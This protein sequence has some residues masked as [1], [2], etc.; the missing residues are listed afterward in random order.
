MAFIQVGSGQLDLQGLINTVI[1]F[2]VAA[3]VIWLFFKLSD[4]HEKF[5]KAMQ[6][7]WQDFIKDIQED[8][9]IRDLGYQSA[10]R[11]FGNVLKDHTKV[12]M[13]VEVRKHIE[14]RDKGD[15]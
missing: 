5:V 4:K 9:K 11:E 10:L 3:I 1:Q 8:N 7:D 12:L 13:D 2:P 14:A 6:D 15:G